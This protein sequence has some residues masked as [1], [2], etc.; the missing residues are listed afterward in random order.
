MNKNY[1]FEGILQE[2]LKINFK[3]K[4]AIF[5]HINY[6]NNYFFINSKNKSWLNQIKFY[7]KFIEKYNF[8]IEINFF[9]NYCKI[10]I[11]DRELKY[12]YQVEPSYFESITYTNGIKL[13]ET[14]NNNN[15]ISYKDYLKN[16]RVVIVAP[17]GYLKGLNKGIEIDNYDIVVRL[18]TALPIKE[19]SK[20]DIGSKTNIL[21]NCLNK[22]SFN[23]GI[24][25]FENFELDWIA[26]PYPEIRPF[27]N[28]IKQFH[29]ENKS[30]FRFHLIERMFYIDIENKMGTRPN[31]GIGAIL[32][33][34][35][36]PI[37]ELYITG[38]TFLL[39]SGY[40]TEYKDFIDTQDKLDEYMKT[41]LHDRLSQVKYLKPILENDTR[42]KMD[43]I[44]IDII[45]E[46]NT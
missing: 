23:G 17:G 36:Y 43:Q 45:S 10:K 35:Q 30:K 11:E 3:N 46:I 7:F 25:D 37:K 33:L 42:I 31:T 40:L 16:K 9:Q 24:I 21:Y 4:E 1:I 29:K 39:K 8:R 26:C 6:R 32:D 22:A 27:K 38:F 41:N 44:L 14:N 13:I 34:L 19:E 2:N 15:N 5:L 28:D 20:N 18:N 12:Y